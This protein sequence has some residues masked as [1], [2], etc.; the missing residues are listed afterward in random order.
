MP[1]TRLVS[2]ALAAALWGGPA[3]SPAWAQVQPS[4]P[5]LAEEDTITLSSGALPEVL[6]TAPRVTLA[7][8]LHRVAQGEA[9]RDSMIQDQAFTATVRV[10]RDVVKAE[11]KL[12]SEVVTRIYKKKPDMIREVPLRRWPEKQERGAEVEFT[13]GTGERI[14]SFA[15]SPELRN[16]FRYR[17]LGREL[18][19]G[20]V[21]YRV[22]Y[23]P[24]SPLAAFAPRGTVWIDTNDFIIIRQEVKF[25]R[26]PTP[27]LFKSIDR[28]IVER[29]PQPSGPWAMSR[30]MMR[31]QTT[32]PIPTLGS[33][34]DVA[35]LLGDYVVNAGL[36]DEFFDERGGRRMPLTRRRER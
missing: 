8:I 21:I 14:V 29:S 10:L 4:M 31:V 3:A 32:V 12:I 5:T 6:V 36:E 34:F 2:I 9:R 23:E 7:E 13:P 19:G 18:V 17:I 16:Q 1:P 24:R 26:S 22:G 11:P 20:H 27:L 30:I 25:D 28:M 15:F 33:S 35:L